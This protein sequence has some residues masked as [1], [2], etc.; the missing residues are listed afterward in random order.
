[1]RVLNFYL[2]V[3]IDPSKLIIVQYNMFQ[4]KKHNTKCPLLEY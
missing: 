4:L 1:M 3:Y 2:C